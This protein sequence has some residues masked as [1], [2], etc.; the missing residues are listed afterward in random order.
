MS[1]SSQ[2]AVPPDDAADAAAP[3]Y[4]HRAAQ[5]A[6][7][8]LNL[9][10]LWQYRD[11]LFLL[12]WRDLSANYRQSIVG[13]GW[14]LFKPLFL[15]GGVHA[16]LQQGRHIVFGPA[17]LTRCSCSPACCPGCIFGRSEWQSSQSVVNSGSLLTKVYFPR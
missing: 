6:G 13:F 8:T 10:E 3:R 1:M 4:R 16:R 5:P 12:V 9:R 2:A 14:A 11:L 15:D 17:Y 7:R